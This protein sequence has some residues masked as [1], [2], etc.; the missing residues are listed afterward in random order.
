MNETQK[1][2]DALARVE[3]KLDFHKSAL[4]DYG[5]RISHLEKKFWTS[6][7]AAILSIGAYIKSL[8]P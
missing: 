5:S 6:V 8:F 7:G 4:D 2:L 1:I 3:T